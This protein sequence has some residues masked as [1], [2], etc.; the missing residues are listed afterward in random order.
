PF[1][2]A[3]MGE[4]HFAALPTALYGGVLLMSGIAYTL[5]QRAIIAK[6]GHDSLLAGAVG[7]DYKSK[8]SVI[9]YVIAIVL[10]FVNEWLADA[11]YV[12]VALMWFIPDRRIEH[13]VEKRS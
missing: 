3:W 8:A 5:L 13:V 12:F 4:N 7:R 11:I 10:A 1:A 2:T 9:L 6:Q